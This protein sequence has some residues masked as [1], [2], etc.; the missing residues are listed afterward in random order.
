MRV[1]Q[2]INSL[3][4]GG[5]EQLIVDSVPIYQEKGL[6]MD[7]LIL[8][9]NKTVFKRELEQRSSGK[10]IWLTSSSIYNPLLIL[11]IIPYFRKYDIIHAHLF[12]TLYWVVLAKW[13]S[14]S[15]SKIFYTEHNTENRRRSHFLLKI[16]D[17]FIYSKLTFIGCISQGTYD[18]LNSHLKKSDR[19]KVI[20][21]G[22]NLKRFK[23][24]NENQK[25]S[26]FSKDDTVLIQVSSFKIQ[27]DQK[28][29]IETLKYLPDNIK[30]LLVGDGILRS[31]REKQ[32]EELNLG[33]RIKFLGIRNDVPL[34]LSSSD[35]VVLSS[36][37]E[38][39]GLAIV[40]GMA[41]N[42][43]V[44]ASDVSGLREI[45][46]NYG[47]LFEQGNAKDLAKQIM[48]L[49]ENK[50]LY[51]RIQK[52]CLDRAKDFQIEKMVDDYIN[53]YQKEII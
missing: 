23:G 15:K 21:N 30:L 34:L 6:E 9:N 38:G 19:L 35:I 27:K 39:F 4:T 20:N 25:R 11:K 47:L 36:F 42:K 41:A 51:K 7:V 22:I 28:T 52:A 49:Y 12:P 1:L 26:F 53:E 8:K 48:F 44:V 46:R 14:F 10:I 17:R 3:D 40:E 16:I 50:E 43:P 2:I 31:E 24:L 5:A 13:F 18:N 45:V 29:L 37:Y 32:V 33:S